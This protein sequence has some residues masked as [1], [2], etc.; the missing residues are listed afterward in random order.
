MR[1][2]VMAGGLGTRL[3][4]LTT[5]VPKPLLPVVGRPM[6][7]HMLLLARE[8]GISEA[9]VTVQHLAPM[10]RRRLGDGADLGMSITYGTEPGPLGTAGGVRLAVAGDDDQAL[11]V[12]SGD[13]VTD[14]NLGDIMRR[15]AESGAQLTMGLTRR[16]DPRE[17]GLV[18]LDDD[19]WVRRFHEKPEWGE[20]F[21]DTVSTGIYVVSAE[22]LARI[23]PDT[24]WDWSKQVIPDL[25]R[26]GA[27]VA[28]VVVNGYW[29]DVGDLAAYRQ[30]QVDTLDRRV[31]LSIPGS[32][33]GDGVWIGDG[34][35]IAAGAEVV[36]P[37]F[38]GDRSV[39]DEGA[40]LLPY[41]VLGA[42]SLVRRGA[43][44]DRSTI[45]DNV[46]LGAEVDLMGAIVGRGCEVGAGTRISEGAVVADGCILE[47]EVDVSPGSMVYP[48][49]SVESGTFVM[50]SVVWDSKGHRSVIDGL[51]MRGEMG[52]E[53]TPDTVVRLASTLGTLLSR[54]ATVAL[55][56]DHSG[57]AGAYHA[58]LVGAL[59]A[60]GLT[61]HLLRTVPL[62]VLRDH[63]RHHADAGIYLRVAPGDPDSLDMVIVRSDGR[64]VGDM[65][66][67]LN[68]I[69]SR[70]EF[71]RAVPGAIGAVV[72]Q[73]LA[74]QEYANR[75]HEHVSTGPSN[76]VRIVVDA[77]GG[78]AATTL[79]TLLEGMSAELVLLGTQPDLTTAMW[80]DSERRQRVE[81]LANIVVSTGA[82]LGVAIDAT[83]ERLWLVDERGNVLDD[84]RALLVVLD[85]VVSESHGAVAVLPSTASRIAE[86]V[87]DFH[88]AHVR[89]VPRATAFND[90]SDVL[91][92]CDGDGGFAVPGA[93]GERDALATTYA[94]LGWVARTQLALSAIDA[95]IP[96]T[97]GMR[98]QVDTPWRLKAAVL[99]EVTDRAGD[100][101]IDSTDGVRIC[102]P[103]GAWCLVLPHPSES[104]TS[105]WV[106]A[107]TAERARELADSWREQI[108]AIIAQSPSARG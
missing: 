108:G 22:V 4:P 5:G 13:A 71:R 77:M 85:L 3:R 15:H 50:G 88:H 23:P 94:L 101:A 54:G 24:P 18:A 25:L 78:A 14:V 60:A 104:R 48:G 76:S 7:E 45:H 46:Y 51:G 86:Q 31:R 93:G 92:V 90:G 61:V 33:R 64:N 72:A 57:S 105:L 12:L 56:R 35:E 29:E 16:D 26:S 37:S 21:G 74:T 82:A 41:S 95:R 99:R 103:D 62:P 107:D 75:I 102:E 73:P 58:I 32:D 55:G 44:I 91:L 39:I 9:V 28:G 6:V 36:G 1:A 65:A 42:H 69:Y 98:V 47:R 49:K 2:V 43:R 67:E 89:R 59:R 38:I 63:V 34:V 106:E 97:H 87:A 81:E 79:P 53:V 10:L 8:H 84:D 96:R 70:R 66:R 100:R 30:V 83:G 17:F 27:P 40:Q 20:V 19:G 80:S 52:V 11:L 68:R